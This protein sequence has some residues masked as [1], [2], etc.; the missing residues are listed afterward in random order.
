M[1][2]IC[3]Y[4]TAE[5]SVFDN[6]YGASFLRKTLSLLYPTLFTCLTLQAFLYEFKNKTEG[7]KK[8]QSRVKIMGFYK[9]TKIGIMNP[10]QHCP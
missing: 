9:Y 8:R 1:F 7:R 4:F 2:F 10:E 3:L 5:H 6:Q